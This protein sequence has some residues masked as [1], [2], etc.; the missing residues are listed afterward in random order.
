MFGVNKYGPIYKGI[1]LKSDN[2]YKEIKEND[3]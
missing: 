1:V 2:F 3:H